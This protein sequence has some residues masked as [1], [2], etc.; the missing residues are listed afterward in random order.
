MSF[1][2]FVMSRSTI[3]L[4]FLFLLAVTASAQFRAGVQ[5]TVTDSTGAVVPG[6]RVVLTNKETSQQQETTTS[7]EGFYRFSSLPPGVYSVS[8]ERQNFKKSLIDDVRVQAEEIRGQD[9][10]LETGGITETVTVTADTADV[11]LDTEDANIRKNI[12]TEEVLQL[13]QAGRDPYELARLAPGVFG[14][15]ARR[16]GGV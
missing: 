14:A 13:P 6:A 4:A 5:G 3:V 9:V 11:T 8:V 16:A 2:R 10:V 1:A 12:S 15:R 7:D